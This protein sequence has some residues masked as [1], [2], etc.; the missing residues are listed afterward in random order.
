MAPSPLR[1]LSQPPIPPDEETPPS[2]RLLVA[3]CSWASFVGIH[4]FNK[5]QGGQVTGRLVP[6]QSWPSGSLP[7]KTSVS[8]ESIS[9]P[10]CTPNRAL[11]SFI[12]F[13]GIIDYSLFFPR[14]IGNFNITKCT[15]AH[16]HKATFK[17]TPYCNTVFFCFIIY[18]FQHQLNCSQVL[19]IDIKT[20]LPQEQVFI[21]FSPRL[22]N[23]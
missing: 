1:Q 17:M 22:Q 3:H 21:F 5:H 18:I 11:F 15:V 23:S 2:S 12:L 6:H 13:C 20:K 4:I 9:L 16:G 7:F 14:L 19:H 8:V 10:C